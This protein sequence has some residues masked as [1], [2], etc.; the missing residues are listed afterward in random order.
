MATMT[1]LRIGVDLLTQAAVFAVNGILQIAFRVEAARMT[2]GRYMIDNA[3]E[4]EKALR[5]WLREQTLLAVVLELY[6]PA[7]GTSYEECRVEIDYLADPKTEA[8]RPNVAQLEELCKKL[9]QLPP[10]AQFGFVVSVAP[11][12]TKVPGWEPCE[13]KEL[14][15]GLKEE[16]TIGDGAH[17]YGQIGGRIVYRESNW[18]QG[19][20]DA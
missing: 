20:Q 11:G 7:T 17:G 3:D 9:A 12:A 5:I 8:T 18:N 2:G 10:D 6:S 4:I 13:F 16:H 19:R 1:S 15:G 14:A